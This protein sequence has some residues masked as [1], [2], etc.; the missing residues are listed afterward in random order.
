MA[1]ELL[2]VKERLCGEELVETSVGGML[3]RVAG[4]DLAK[5]LA[6]RFIGRGRSQH[7]RFEHLQDSAAILDEIGGVGNSARDS[8][9][10]VTHLAAE[11]KHADA[12]HTKKNTAHGRLRLGDT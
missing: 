1:K 7:G 4:K 5:R 10:S 11:A 8:D 3:V 6:M 9:A 2:A 12:L